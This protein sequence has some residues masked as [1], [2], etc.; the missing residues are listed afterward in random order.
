M[1]VWLRR[2]EAVVESPEAFQT[3]S[4]AF[5]CDPH[6]HLIVLELKRAR[7]GEQLVFPINARS[8]FIHLTLAFMT[9]PSDHQV[10]E[11]R[12]DTEICYVGAGPNSGHAASSSS[13]KGHLS[14][15]RA[16]RVFGPDAASVAVYNAAA[17]DIVG[18]ALKGMNGTVFAYGQTGGGKT[19]TMRAITRGAVE[20]IFGAIEACRDD[21]EYLI[22]LSA[23]EIYNEVV[24]DLLVDAPPPWAVGGGGSDREEVGTTSFVGPGSGGSMSHGHYRHQIGGVACAEPL[25]L[26]DDPER[27]TVIERLTDVPVESREALEE[28]LQMV[29][30]RRQVGSTG[31]NSES[32]RSHQIVRLTIESR[33]V[34]EGI[35]AG[36]NE[37][38]GRTS[39]VSRDGGVSDWK[40]AKGCFDGDDP[41]LDGCAKKQ[42]PRS[43]LPSLAVWQ[44]TKQGPVLT[45]T[46][47][48]VDLAGSERASKAQSSGVRLK[49]GNHIN[50]SL[51]T[52]GKVIRTLAESNSKEGEGGSAGVGNHNHN[53]IPYRDSKLTRILAS[54]LGGNARTAVLTCVSAAAS[55]MEATR[56]ALFFASQ[57]KRVTNHATVNEVCDDKTLIRRYQAEIAELHR[58]LADGATR[59]KAGSERGE[60]GAE[61][62]ARAREEARTAE[63]AR[64]KA[65][66]RLRGLE[67]FLLRGPRDVGE[68]GHGLSRSMGDHG[69]R[70][71]R[72]R[73]WSPSPAPKP[74]RR[75]RRGTPTKQHSVISVGGNTLSEATNGDGGIFGNL[76]G[77]RRSLGFAMGSFGGRRARNSHHRGRQM[78][79]DGGERG[80]RRSKSDDS[81]S[82]LEDSGSEGIEEEEEEEEE[83]EVGSIMSPLSEGATPRKTLSK[84]TS[85][86]PSHAAAAAARKNLLKSPLVLS[87]LGLDELA[88]IR[89]ARAQALIRELSAEAKDAEEASNAA[90]RVSEND[91]IAGRQLEA[92]KTCLRMGV[93]THARRGESSEEVISR[94]QEQLKVLQEDKVVGELMDAAKESLIEGLE[95]ELTR[96]RK[97]QERMEAA[98]AAAD[99]L[100]QKLTL[101]ETDIG[102]FW[103]FPGDGDSVS[104]GEGSSCGDSVNPLSA[105][106][107]VVSLSAANGGDCL[108]GLLPPAPKGATSSVPVHWNN[109][110]GLTDMFGDSSRSVLGSPMKSLSKIVTSSSSNQDNNTANSPQ[111]PSSPKAPLSSLSAFANSE[112][113]TPRRRGHGHSR[114]VSR[115]SFGSGKEN[116][117]SPDFVNPFSDEA[118]A[119]Y[120]AP[121]DPSFNDQT[122]V[123]PASELL[124]THDTSSTSVDLTSWASDQTCRVLTDAQVRKK[125]QRKISAA[126]AAAAALG[127]EEAKIDEDATGIRSNAK[128]VIVRQPGQQRDERQGQEQTNSSG[129]STPSAAA[130]AARAAVK[131]EKRTLK[132]QL[133]GL[134]ER[135]REA[136]AEAQATRDAMDGYRDT[137]QR[138]E[139]Q[140]RLLCA[141]VLELEATIAEQRQKEQAQKRE[142]AQK[143]EREGQTVLLP[144]SAR[145]PSFTRQTL[146]GGLTVN[147]SW[148]GPPT[149]TFFLPKIVKLW[150]ELHVPLLHRSQFLIAFRGRET[151]YYEA[152]HRRLTWLKSTLMHE[153]WNPQDD[154]CS[155]GGLDGFLDAGGFGH[156]SGGL[157]KTRRSR[158]TF[159]PT[160]RAAERLLKRERDELRR[161]ARRLDR[162]QL[163]AIFTN[164]GIDLGGKRRKERLIGMLWSDGDALAAEGDARHH[165]GGK[166]RKNKGKSRKMPRGGAGSGDAESVFARLKRH[167]ELVLQLK[168]VDATEDMF[169]LVFK[170]DTVAATPRG[171]SYAS[172]LASSAS[173]RLL[174]IATA[175][176]RDSLKRLFS[177]P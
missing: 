35:S 25:R 15:C 89:H 128:P 37:G 77:A 92:E 127:E 34:R 52:L 144:T 11:V 100:Q 172:S 24:R 1:T 142:R 103:K 169:N 30:A 54:S 107:S 29:E 155:G 110:Y 149:A 85:F 125:E 61:E 10:W 33:E 20:D 40:S 17:K 168:S 90:N 76:L 55:A 70:H 73:S 115:G 175:P 72:R 106:S 59:A 22:H 171:A 16:D 62:L 2:N 50:R 145:S 58:I 102:V 84:L 132:H 21:R 12:K 82:D 65:E 148:A 129:A 78:G 126:F 99:A 74:A 45:A 46:L 64:Q 176:V 28:L 79:Y 101:L 67:K 109:A 71:R 164:W 36:E 44:S 91:S 9:L 165:V 31:M 131:W 6:G 49:E 38:E 113:N 97:E 105:G 96:L 120:T 139:F 87:G 112:A 143:E 119:G 95:C 98:Q 152:E 138:V 161:L 135:F 51:L 7:T 68:S 118:V 151:F 159:P 57:A 41:T 130:A 137:V 158:Q 150:R 8:P 93:A 124:I 32:S 141:Q 47:N 75:R 156:S 42:E 134:R 147:D 23:V 80:K 14:V 26:M 88:V 167:A 154:E 170:A 48:F 4:D 60:E 153:G 104:G 122:A 114:S 162:P 18:G 43:S 53:H 66:A 174:T 81:A 86:P 136:L 5:G 140:K 177:M 146:P 13:S 39:G 3:H 69:T 117:G 83:E 123:A 19:H 94:L 56:A 166:I 116:F 163:E 160:L 108:D 27:G 157:D 133:S 63:E 121:V 111:L 173:R